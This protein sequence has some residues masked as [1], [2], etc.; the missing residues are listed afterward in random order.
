MSI[1]KRSSSPI[2][3]SNFLRALSAKITSIRGRPFNFIAQQDVPEILLVVLDELKGLSPIADNVCN[4]PPFAFSTSCDTCSCSS[5]EEEKVSMLIL[6]PKKHII[7]SFN[8]FLQAE[9]LTDQNKRFCYQCSM[10]FKTAVKKQGYCAAGR[11]FNC[12]SCLD[13]PTQGVRSQKIHH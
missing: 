7:A 9:T 1:L 5:E 6:P 13:L 11:F 2:D 4:H 8:A 3:P 10:F 12:G